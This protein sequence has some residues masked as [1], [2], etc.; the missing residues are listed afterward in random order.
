MNAY[1]FCIPLKEPLLLKGKMYSER[2]GVLIERQG[3]W[4]EASPLP[5]FSK[6]SIDDVIAAM[7]GQ[8]VPP[9]S[10]QFALSVLEERAIERAAVPWN[11]LLVGD[12]DRVMTGVER[13][14]E[15]RCQAAKLKVGR[16]DLQTEIE[17]VRAVRD[18]LPGEVR[19]RLD[20]NQAWTM[21]EATRF[22]EALE[23][24]DLDYV[25]EP[26]KDSRQLE[27]LFSRT[28]IRYALDE[29]LTHDV[30]I[31]AWPNAAALIC[32]P[33]ILGGRAAV[34]RLS[35]T[36][37]PITFTAAFETGVGIA[38]IVQLAAEF[39][40]NSAAGLDTLDWLEDDLL[41]TTPEKRAGMMIFLGEPVVDSSKLEP[42]EL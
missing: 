28:G 22:I 7:R 24:V 36:G 32:K 38:R 13:C 42:I 11:Y 30:Q 4:V 12:H 19:L 18:R 37:K 1:R 27:D 17:L 40:P 29:T 16:G 41:L 10:L 23:D 25:E 8:Q 2:K 39:S 3:K 35:V 5:G 31:D 15:A 6:E 9:P 20:A 14:L 26:L 21:D 33:T 34:E